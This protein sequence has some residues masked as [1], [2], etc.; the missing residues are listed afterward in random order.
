M[1]SN[2]RMG[3]RAVR[4]ARLLVGRSKLRRPSDRIEGLVVVLLCAAFMA[5]VAAAPYC[6][7][8]LYQQQRAAA[9]RL[10]PATAVLV[11]SGQS[12]SYGSAE[13]TAAARWRAPDG[14]ELKGVLTALTAP[15]ICGAP[16]GSRVQVWLTGAGQPEQPPATAAESALSSVM[17]TI[18]AECGA[19]VGLVLCYWL[20]RLVLDRRR[21]AAWASEWTMTG[22]RWT[23]RL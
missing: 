18:G 16:A 22:P 9:A 8:W 10:H 14:R 7:R 15:G 20:C 6:G 13:P 3:G 1:A 2:S 19:A 5:A 23:T 11:Q 12:A 17:L 4:L 21:M